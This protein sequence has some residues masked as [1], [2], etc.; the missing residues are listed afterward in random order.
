MKKILTHDIMDALNKRVPL[1]VSDFEFRKMKAQ[2]VKEIYTLKDSDFSKFGIYGNY[3]VILSEGM[4]VDIEAP[5]NLSV[6]SL[7][8]ILK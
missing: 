5:A 8:S 6:D 4:F 3:V 1:T 7:L 2:G